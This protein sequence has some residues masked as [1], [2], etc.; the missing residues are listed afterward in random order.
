MAR[1]TITLPSMLESAAGGRRDFDVEADTVSGALRRLTELLPALGT[2]LFD[3]GGTLR[4]HVLCFHNATSTRWS[5]DDA[6]LADGDTI[7]ILQA[8]SGG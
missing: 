7:R 3:E 8:V 5:D 2:L 4:E 1:V 6:A